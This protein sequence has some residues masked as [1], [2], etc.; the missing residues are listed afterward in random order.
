MSSALSAVLNTPSIKLYHYSKEARDV[1]L[2]V[3]M[4]DYV[5]DDFEALDRKYRDIAVATNGVHYYDTVSLMIDRIPLNL[6]SMSGNR[7]T[8]WV[9]GDV[10]YEHEIIITD[11]T[12]TGGGGFKVYSTPEE[13]D[14]IRALSD[15]LDYDSR[16]VRR[17]LSAQRREVME[18]NGY[19]GNTAK[20][21]K[22][23]T[24]AF[25][26]KIARYYQE[27]Y[28]NPIDANIYNQYAGQVPHLMMSIFNHSLVPTK[29][30]K[31]K[32]K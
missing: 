3:H 25:V 11:A 10:L 20:A 21:L 8:V 18:R 24:Y 32:I 27:M 15:D 1:I 28:D 6:A 30:R 26:G 31:V 7:S 4:S 23:G 13:M 29:I 2:P 22:T 16:K 17:M 14:W 9:K 19:T 5:P 12:F